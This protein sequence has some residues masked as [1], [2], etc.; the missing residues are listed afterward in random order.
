MIVIVFVKCL[1]NRFQ[2]FIDC[3]QQTIKWSDHSQNITSVEPSEEDSFDTGLIV[4]GIIGIV[5]IIIM[6]LVFVYLLYKRPKKAN[7]STEM[8]AEIS[9]TK[10][11]MSSTL[12]ANI[13]SN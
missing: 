12:N 1:Q 5:V 4:I 6:I 13:S 7:K 2:V 10:R 8:S 9:E 11:T 3:D